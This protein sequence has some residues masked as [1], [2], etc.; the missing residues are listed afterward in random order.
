MRERR[1]VVTKQQT[2]V[3]KEAIL[4]AGSGLVPINTLTTIVS[5]THQGTTMYLTE[6]TGTGQVEGRFELHINGVKKMVLR[7]SASHRN[8]QHRFTAGVPIQ[9]N[10]LVEVKAY[11]DDSAVAKTFDVTLVGF[12]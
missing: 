3:P 1:W 11:Q 6:W 8:V 2:P 9:A 5:Y 12:R 10:D 7:A 4:E